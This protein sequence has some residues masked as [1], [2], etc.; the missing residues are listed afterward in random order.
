MYPIRLLQ[1]MYTKLA[2]FLP[3]RANNKDME[4]AFTDIQKI[5]N[6]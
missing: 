2:L 6:K 1:K 4:K 3:R 5:I